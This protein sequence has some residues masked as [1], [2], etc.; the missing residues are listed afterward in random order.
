MQGADRFRF[1]NELRAWIEV[2][3]AGQLSD[4]GYTGSGLI[5]ATTL[6]LGALKY[7]F[8]AVK[9]PDL[10]RERERPTVYIRDRAGTG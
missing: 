4:A 9:L 6:Q 3:G 5:G 10:R 8:E 7:R 1:A 2:N